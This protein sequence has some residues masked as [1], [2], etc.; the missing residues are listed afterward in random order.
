MG[1]AGISGTLGSRLRLGVS[2]ALASLLLVQL[3]AALLPMPAFGLWVVRLIAR[4][5]WLFAVPLG[6]LLFVIG[7]RSWM[8]GVGLGA[9]VWGF[10]PLLGAWPMFGTVHGGFSL[11]EYATGTRLGREV[12]VQRDLVLEPSR[13][14]LAL[15]LYPGQGAGPRPLLVVLHGGSWQ[16]GDKGEVAHAS[17]AL[18]AA[19]WSVA[20]LRYRLAP[21]H[22]F[23]APVADVKC[24]LGRLRG[25]AA[26]LNVDPK[27]VVLLGRSAGGHL[28]LIAGYSMGVS[29][30]EALPPSCAVPEQPVQGVVAVYPLIDLE[31]TYKE[32]PSPDL[33]DARDA[34][35]KLLGG[36]PEQVKPLY[37]AASPVRWAR[38]GRRLPPT[39]LVHGQADLLVRIEHSKK[40][41]DALEAG[42]HT[43]RLLGIP[44]A[45]HGFDVRSGGI[46]EQLT[47]AAVLDFLRGL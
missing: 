28:A 44:D 38:A 9:A 40:L 6:A 4:E 35:G 41:Y 23:P 39:L 5:T 43:A 3:V 31:G 17:R 10:V 16:R 27:R 22:R 14:D 15:D 7:P 1:S 12:V 30:A 42:R 20:D 47:R 19:G 33:L 32:P 25:E 46:G 11:M 36:S 8:R 34:L 45:D 37:E 2:W 29:G 21:A 24:L 18:A 13:P 26:R